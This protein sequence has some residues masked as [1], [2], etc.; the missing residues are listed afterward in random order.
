VSS[1]CSSSD[2]DFFAEVHRLHRGPTDDDATRSSEGV[3]TA[4]GTSYSYQLPRLRMSLT[5][6][7]ADTRGSYGD[8]LNS[9]IGVY[10]HLDYY[11]TQV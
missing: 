11:L 9:D 5:D 1:V 10:I 6:T 4:T 2:N 7:V 3:L 8:T